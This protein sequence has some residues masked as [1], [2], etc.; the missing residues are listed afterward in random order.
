MSAWAKPK[1]N[2]YQT[3]LF[4][5]TLDDRIPEDHPV[6]LYQELLTIQ[7][8]HSWEQE[9]DQ[10]RGQPAF[11]PRLLAGAILY[12]LSRKINSSRQLEDACCNRLDFMWLV[13][14]HTIDHSTFA[15]FRVRHE[16]K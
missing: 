6:R 9:Y 11:H 4:S 10:T 2:K 14:G 8:W 3:S 7:D 15:A 16:A 13:D 1:I 12:G 5:P